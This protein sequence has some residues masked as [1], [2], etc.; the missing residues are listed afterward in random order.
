MMKDL[1]S[2]HD[3]ILAAYAEILRLC[4]ANLNDEEFPLPTVHLAI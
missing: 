4:G 3:V 2:I 1:E